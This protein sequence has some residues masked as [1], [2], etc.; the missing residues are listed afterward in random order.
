MTPANKTHGCSKTKIYR[1]F[2]AMHA[3]CKNP[4]HISYP[5][6]GAKGV[7][8]CERWAKFEQFIADMGMRKP[9]QSIDRVDNTK[10]YSPENC[11]WATVKEQANNHSNNRHLTVN[12]ETKTLAQWG[13]TVGMS[14]MKILSRIRR[15]WTTEDA[16]LLRH[17]G[18]GNHYRKRLS[19]A[20]Q[21]R[22]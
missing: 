21:A 1:V 17:L 10:G 16:V 11:R 8:V 6:Y 3:R 5:R 9:G 15:G 19:A 12:G 18:T 13:E 4:N 7:T 20:R 2:M 22:A 14:P